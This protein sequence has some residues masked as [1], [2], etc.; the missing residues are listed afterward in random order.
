MDIMFA[1]YDDDYNTL[2]KYTLYLELF[3]LKFFF[4]K[5]YSLE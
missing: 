1:A 3:R 2:K 4:E 5:I